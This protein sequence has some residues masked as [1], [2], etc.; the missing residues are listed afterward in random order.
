[1]EMTN[2]D[3]GLTQKFGAGLT[4]AINK[5]GMFNVRR[6]GTSWRDIHPYLHLIN[7]PWPLF[8]AVVVIGYVVVNLL[9]ASAYH[10]LGPG[11]LA[12]VEG[13]SEADRFLS[14]FYF[15]AQTLTTVGYGGLSPKGT[16]AN[17]LAVF[18]AMLGWLS[19][20]VA[21]GLLYGRVSR[22]SARLGFS[23]RMVVAPFQSGSSVQFRIVNQRANTLM[24][25]EAMVLLMT[26]QG[27]PGALRRE[28]DLLKLERRRIFFFPLTWTIVHPI[29]NESPFLGK[30]PADLERL[31]AEVLI[32]VKAF[33]DTFSQT[34][35]AR[36]S[37]RYDEIVW[38]GRF[39]PAFE[40][41][42][43]GDMILHVDRVG[44]Y[45]AAGSL[46]TSA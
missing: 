36:Y 43:S 35:H 27:A 24:D 40:I 28:Y 19:L 7:M 20:A 18:E 10:S 5:D 34:V 3:P 23:G 8:V 26:V 6:T 15:S 29:D 17:M 16:A 38:D 30:T 44:D 32:L 45:A 1:M 14:A 9:F 21:T 4:R 33:D 39:K 42:E 31:Q 37:Y 22:P 25:V 11:Q 46:G 41:G 13:G 2:F 12:G